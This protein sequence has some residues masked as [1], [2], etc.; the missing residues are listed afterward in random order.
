MPEVRKD[1]LMNGGVVWN[2]LELDDGT[3]LV[4]HKTVLRHESGREFTFDLGST[5]FPRCKV[6]SWGG[7]D[8]QVC[9]TPETI[10]S[11]YDAGE[12]EIVEGEGRL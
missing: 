3:Y 4:C 7:H 9:L 8:M 1:D 11:M 6:F 2:G 12:L 10:Q 5:D